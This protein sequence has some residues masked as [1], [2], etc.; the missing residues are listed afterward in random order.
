MA[1]PCPH[2]GTIRWQVG[3]E[4]LQ[5]RP[6]GRAEGLEE[7]HVDLHCHGILSGG[8]HQAAGKALDPKHVARQLVRQC[9]RMGV[10][11]QAERRA[12]PRDARSKAVEWL[13][14]SRHQ[15]G[16]TSSGA[17]ASPTGMTAV[18]AALRSAASGLAVDSA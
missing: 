15:A 1:R 4:A 16:D 7:G 12:E 13:R 2:P 8:L 10:D 3:D 14:S 17:A 18:V 9:I 11:P 6:A 5:R